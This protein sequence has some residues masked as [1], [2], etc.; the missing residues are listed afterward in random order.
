MLPRHISALPR[1][2]DYMQQLL[3]L[4]ELGAVERCELAARLLLSLR[5]DLVQRT[6]QPYM[7]SSASKAF[8]R[9]QLWEV[10]AAA[11]SS[12]ER[13]TLVAQLGSFF[14]EFFKLAA[15]VHPGCTCMLCG[16]GVC[17]SSG[18]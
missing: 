3:G 7:G 14:Q 12:S 10:P 11:R 1:R 17:A 2:L 15:K 6:Q 18:V 13:H 4:E 9:V 16:W 5:G 8:W